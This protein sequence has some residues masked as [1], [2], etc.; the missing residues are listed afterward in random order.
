MYDPTLDDFIAMLKSDNP[1]ERRNAAWML[2]RQR[3]PLCVPSLIHA[4][5]DPDHDVRLRVAESLGNLR[6]ERAIMPLITALGDDSEEIRA[7]VIQALG[8]HQDYRALPS[9]I[10]FLADTNIQL[11][12]S[13]AQ[14]LIEMPDISALPA[15]LNAFLTDGEHLVQYLSRQ[16]L[17]KIGGEALLN[18]LMF[19]LAGDHS[20][21][22]KIEMIELL[23][24][25]GDTRALPAIQSFTTHED[26]FLAE[27][28]QWAQKR[29]S[30]R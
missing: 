6:D 15:L 23:A 2:G 29:L 10:P 3:D 28:A 12:A 7:Q 17:A 9:I 26:N 19:E 25:L 11:R 1:D 14:A 5:N 8:K 27:T 4:L 22:V 18:A 24:G 20:A 13:A 21:G 30:P 16:A